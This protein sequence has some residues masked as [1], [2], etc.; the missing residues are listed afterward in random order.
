MFG[1]FTVVSKANTGFLI[2]VPKIIFDKLFHVSELREQNI[3][4][5]QFSFGLKKARYLDRLF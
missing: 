5:W 4:F 2:T 3:R 1:V